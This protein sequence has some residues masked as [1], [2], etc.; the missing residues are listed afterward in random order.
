MKNL[1]L[2][3][4]AS[5]FWVLVFYYVMNTSIPSLTS[6]LVN[7]ILLIVIFEVLD[8]VFDRKR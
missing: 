8:Y 3:C 6:W 2:A 1:I 5:A 4:G 7:I